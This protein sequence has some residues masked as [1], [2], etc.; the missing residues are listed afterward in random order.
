MVQRRRETY[1]GRDVTYQRVLTK[2]ALLTVRKKIGGDLL[3][4]LYLLAVVRQCLWGVDHQV[5]AWVLSCFLALVLWGLHLRF[6]QSRD[7]GPSM[8]FWIVGVAPILFIYLLRFAFPDLSYDV[9]NHRLVQ[10]ERA[11]RGFL[12]IKGDFYPSFLPFNPTP[13]ILTGIFRHLLG[14]RLGTV[15]SLLALVWTGTEVEKLLKPYVANRWLRSVAALAVVFT[16]YQLFEVNNYINDLLPLPLFIAAT[17]RTLELRPGERGS[18]Y[19]AIYIALLLGLSAALKLT[20][21]LLMIP[22]LFVFGVRIIFASSNTIKDKAI[23]ISAAIVA[24][25]VPQLPFAIYIYR[26]TQSPVFPLYN[27]VIKSPYWPLLNLDD[28]RWGPKTAIETI[29]WP[30]ISTFH[31]ERL[32]EIGVYSGRVCLGFIVAIAGLLIVRKDSR[33]LWLCFITLCCLV[34]WSLTAGYARYAI[35]IEVLAGVVTI[36]LCSYL[37]QKFSKAALRAIVIAL[38]GGVLAAQGALACN[39]VLNYEWSQRPTLFTQFHEYSSELR[40]LFRDRALMKFQSADN[41]AQLDQVQTWIVSDV[42]TNGIEVLLKPE[43]PMIAVHNHIYLDVPAGRRQFAQALAEVA[44]TKMYT[45]VMAE[46]V[47]SAM[48]SIK[49]RGLGVGNATPMELRFF[50][51]FYRFQMSLIEV[52][53]RRRKNIEEQLRDLSVNPILPDNDFVVILSAPPPPQTVHAGEKI[54][55][56]VKVKNGSESVWLAK[57]DEQGRHRMQLRNRWL[58][59]GS[60][61]LVTD[62]DGGTILPQ[63]LLPGE[64]VELPIT[65]T[66]PSQP[67]D[68]ILDLD[69]VQEQVTWFSQKGYETL[70]FNVRVE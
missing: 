29:F 27:R 55:L 64:E 5:V 8:Q 56:T 32:S 60:E 24:F 50:S 53:P 22:L 49:R 66:A 13:E 36:G 46:D 26:R 63:N 30:V 40:F 58:E 18:R 43:L 51:N 15:I 31:P 65:V 47:D 42:K 62:Q 17:R 38:F 16:E 28:S 6:K 69:M 57:G 59:A 48:D 39:Y 41:K 68:Y 14:Y 10:S 45:L 54:T 25:F 61:K 70:R 20:N 1:L 19:E 21:L 7:D 12:F 44:G 3:L 33:L 11:L 34:F 9:L 67:G 37:A 52:L 4:P 35:N 2:E 23:T